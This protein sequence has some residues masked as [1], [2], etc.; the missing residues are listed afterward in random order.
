LILFECFTNEKNE[1]RFKQI[2]LEEVFDIL[3]DV[4]ERQ[5]I[6][7]EVIVSIGQGQFQGGYIR[8]DKFDSIIEILNKYEWAESLKNSLQDKK[9][10]LSDQAEE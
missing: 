4:T 7:E 9:D 10:H 1:I 2:W 5:A 8:K 3:E 6:I